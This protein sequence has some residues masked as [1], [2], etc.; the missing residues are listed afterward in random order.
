MA[1]KAKT[2]KDSSLFDLDTLQFDD[3]GQ[4]TSWSSKQR[5]RLRQNM[6]NSPR[7]SNDGTAR[8]DGTSHSKSRFEKETL[9]DLKGSP[10]MAED[11]EF[12]ELFF[13]DV[14]K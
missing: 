12:E 11:L 1:S 3:K 5:L 8:N 14:E 9:K 7:S 13:E 2:S 10:S 4:R 6:S